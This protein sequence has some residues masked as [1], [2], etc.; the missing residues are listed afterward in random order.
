MCS[1]GKVIQLITVPHNN[2]TFRETFACETNNEE[3]T[4]TRQK[5]KKK[6]KK[7]KK[8]ETNKEEKKSLTQET[9]K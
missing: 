7:K 1:L 2:V 3:Q 4:R 9:D 6:K 8:N 5:K